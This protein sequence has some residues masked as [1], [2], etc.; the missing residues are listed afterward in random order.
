MKT[1]ECSREAEIFDALA[2]GRWP[3]QTSDELRAHATACAVCADVVEVAAPLLAE[4]GELSEEARI[5]SSAVMWW[6]AQMRA[7]QEAAREAS[8]PIVVAQ[9]IATTAALIL[10][11]GVLYVGAP[12]LREWFGSLSGLPRVA[13]SADTVADGP[14]LPMSVIA[15]A[16]VMLLLTSVALYFAFKEDRS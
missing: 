9:V 15:I 4:R 10:V 8:R 7:R 14:I 13:L 3:E 16:G 6:R 1:V 5:P 11:G 2:T 12:W